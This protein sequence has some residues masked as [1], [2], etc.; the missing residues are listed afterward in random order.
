MQKLLLVFLFLWSIQW[1]NAQKPTLSFF[2]ELPGKEFNVLF[3]DSSLIDQLV[4]MKA[5][6]RIG[7]HDFSDE[8]T[9]TIKK[10]N[11]AGIPI[12][13]WLLLPE[14]D[15]YWFNMYN[16][17]KAEQRYSD[18]KRWTNDNQLVWK[19]IGIDL[20]LD[21]N[22]A[23]M[24]LKHPWKL[25]WKVYKRLYD[26]KSILSGKEKYQQLIATMKS[27]GYKVESYIIPIIYEEREKGTS[28]FQKLMG[29]VDIETE[30]EIP[31]LYTSAMNNPAILPAYHQPNMPMALGST[32]GGV[33]IEGIELKALNWE[34]LERDL[35]IA[36]KLTNEIH[37]FCLETSVQKGFLDKIEAV[38]FNQP[39]P[40]IKADIAK[41]KSTA[42]IY[43]FLLVVFEHP[44]ILT[45]VII[46]F[47]SGIIWAV[48]KLFQFILKKARK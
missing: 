38:N 36:S 46:G 9:Q 30:I 40:N 15:G 24:A 14:Q 32:G 3:A 43:R 29:I 33:K 41:E 37:I 20:E 25:A 48:F 19:G 8:R 39:M 7:L 10:L 31:M 12:V 28:S 6:I 5:E 1:A 21:I 2:C 47:L 45:I 42:K 16:G 11:K 26:N 22:D 4:R 44:F 18:F 17:A 23:T 34:N 27:D 35:L 13:A